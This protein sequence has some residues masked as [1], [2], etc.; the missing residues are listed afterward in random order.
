MR[1][2]REPIAR[3]NAPLL[4]L[5]LATWGRRQSVVRSADPSDDTPAMLEFELSAGESRDRD[6]RRRRN[7]VI[8][9]TATAAA[10]GMLVV[11]SA[12]AYFQ[13]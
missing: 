5:V 12:T 1:V 8:A 13:T 11:R 2:L 10:T 3:E 4:T 7:V 6:A 9:V